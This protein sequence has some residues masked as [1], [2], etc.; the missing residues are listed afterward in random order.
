MK[1][2]AKKEAGEAIK[3]EMREVKNTETPNIVQRR[4]LHEELAGLDELKV[5][6][7]GKFDGNPML[8]MPW[9]STLGKLCC[10]L[11]RDST[12]QPP[13]WSVVTPACIAAAQTNES[14]R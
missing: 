6:D 7:S 4:S 1:I 5:K 13:A 8:R 12:P 14:P 3:I 2:D 10:S 11:V 9:A